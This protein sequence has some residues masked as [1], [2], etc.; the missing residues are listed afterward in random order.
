LA[1]VDRLVVPPTGEILGPVALDDLHDDEF[2][3]PPRKAQS[4]K[5]SANKDPAGGSAVSSV[6]ADR[7]DVE[8]LPDEPQL[9]ALVRAPQAERKALSAALHAV[10]AGRSARKEG[11]GLRI[12][13]DPLDL[14]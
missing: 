11:G 8:D 5:G 7:R 4:R 3:A 13:V 9:R 10:A 14:F 1:A 12:R 6:T 2:S